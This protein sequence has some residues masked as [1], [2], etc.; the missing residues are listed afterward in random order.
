MTARTGSRGKPERGPGEGTGTAEFGAGTF[1]FWYICGFGGYQTT[2]YLMGSLF[3]EL[4]R[5][6]V[7]RVGAAYLV[8]AWLIVQVIE[9]ISRPLSLPDWTEAFFIVLLLA[10]F[11][12][13][14]IFAW[15]FELTPEGLKK[16]SEVKAE[17]SVTAT[18]G[19]KLN[20]AIIAVLVMS[21]GYFVWERQALVEQVEMNAL[22]ETGEI[23]ETDGTASVAVLPFVNMSA[24]PAQEYF[25]DGI[26]EELLN[27]LAKIPE[28]RVPARTSS[29]QFKG[30]NLDISDVAKQLN[31]KHV[32]E[33]SVR[34]AD[35]RVRVTAQLIE[36]DTGYHL[37][38]ETYDRE[39]DDIFAIQDEISS[40][41]VDALSETLGLRTG[42]APTVRAAAN[43]EA[44]NAYLLAQHQM[45][46]RTKI[47]IE[48]AIPN[49][50][51]ALEYDPDYAPAHAGLGLAW[52]LLTQGGATYGTLTLEESLS[53]A[54]P[55]L[56]RALEIDPELPEAL[57]AMGLL[58]AAQRQ[59]ARALPYFE[60]A[61]ELNPSLTDVRNWYSNSLE[62][63]ARPDDAF[64]EIE[65]AY[66]L[67][68]LS[69]L[70]LNN[71]VND[72]VQRRQFDKAEPVIDRLSQVDLARGASFRGTVHIAQGRAAE[73]VEQ[74]LRAVEQDADNLRLRT[75]AADQLMSLGFS[76]AAI[77]VWPF[78]D[79]LYGVVSGGTDFAYILE[80]AQQRYNKDPNNLGKLANLAWAHWNVGHGDAAVELA[81]R[82]LDKL[83]A[84]Q[85]ASDFTSAILAFDARKRG[86]HERERE[87]L[88]PVN[89]S[90]DQY[91][92]SGIDNG[93]LRAGKAWVSYMLG[94]ESLARANMEKAMFSNLFSI[95]QI[96]FWYEVSG[97]GELP[98]W[99]DLQ[100]RHREY[101]SAE[102][103][104]LLA[105][106]CSENGFEVWQPAPEDCGRKI[107]SGVPN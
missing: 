87:L 8:V 15:A 67:D 66:E 47:D 98:K 96:A 53:R 74:V 16:T 78:P 106:A 35:V 73:G 48:S 30:Q 43:P 76:D 101:M 79:D 17:E 84:D 93:G 10:G 99:R 57:G 5:R 21:L 100:V 11:P 102:S 27:L 1:P 23:V 13:I 45:K 37:W 95:E 31:V 104:K 40:A 14:L 2:S 89:K 61:L 62:S 9:T 103:G 39:L 69:V 82:Y 32:L 24:D 97:W 107:P 71:Y 54:M 80:L 29:F 91:L 60:K 33:G 86:D 6:N 55:H 68:P 56:E 49:F 51:K 3:Q 94:Q 83:P 46:R 92:A 105:I 12:V 38:S 52:Y 81:V 88:E 59:N 19:K 77:G 44:Y 42:L 22:Q 41:I 64:R 34:K 28:I 85:R 90:L 4:K 7:F 18:T 36:A 65:L 26:S 25:S 20:F 63:L 72:L 58:Y 75:Q 50:E 70:T